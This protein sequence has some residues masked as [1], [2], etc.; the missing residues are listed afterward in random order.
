MKEKKLSVV[1]ADDSKMFCE[2]L[3]ALLE[4]VP[5]V[6]RVF[7]AYDGKEALE[8]VRQHPIDLALL[9]VRMPVMDGIKAAEIILKEDTSIKIIGMTSF[10]EEATL[11]DLLRAGVHGIL[12]KRSANRAELATAINEVM[13]GRNYYHEEIRHV[14]DKNIHRM[15]V[16]S[17]TNFSPRELDILRFTCSGKVA[18]EIAVALELSTGSVE[19]YRKELLRKT[20]TKNVAELVTFA[21]RNGLL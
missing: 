17:R 20:N 19:N 18:K 4:K 9:D 13:N 8:I 7:V 21:H 3:A 11:L 14:V 2:S 5:K 10:D 15:N 12:L 16:S 1:V 6:H